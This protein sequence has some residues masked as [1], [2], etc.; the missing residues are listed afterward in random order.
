M[1]LQFSFKL[2][3]EQ[4]SYII[5]RAGA[6][7]MDGPT[8]YVRAIINHWFESGCPPVA[9]AEKPGYKPPSFSTPTA[10]GK[11]GRS[12]GPSIGDQDREN[13]PHRSRNG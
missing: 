8:P 3:P 6:L 9:E 13:V 10:G 12:E 11:K 7:A 2:P 1:A 4:E 5:K